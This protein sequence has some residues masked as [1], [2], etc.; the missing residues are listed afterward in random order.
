MCLY[1][2]YNSIFFNKEKIAILCFCYL[3]RLVFDQSSPAHPVL[4]YGDGD[5]SM[6]EEYKKT[7]DGNYCGLYWIVGKHS[8]HYVLKTLGGES[9]LVV[10]VEAN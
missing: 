6:M 9:M 1:F 2:F 5:L 8:T 4:E 10:L 7:K 3:R